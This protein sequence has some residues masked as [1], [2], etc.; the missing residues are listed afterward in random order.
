MAGQRRNPS[1]DIGQRVVSAHPN[2]RHIRRQLASRLLAFRRF[3][4]HRRIPVGHIRVPGQRHRRFIVPKR[5]SVQHGGPRSG[6]K[7]GQL[8]GQL[9]GWMVVLAVSARQLERQVQLRTD[10]VRHAP[11]PVDGD[12]RE[13]DEDRTARGG[14]RITTTAEVTTYLPIRSRVCVKT[15][16]C[17]SQ[18]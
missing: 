17:A 12:R 5:P 2:D 7:R 4:R 6:R 15:T 9:R 13:R 14:Q 18:C 3:Q 1:V 10:V 11:Q 16:V 8:R